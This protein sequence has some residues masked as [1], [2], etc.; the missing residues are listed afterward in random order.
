MKGHVY[1]SVF[2]SW[3]SPSQPV[4]A[5]P[6]YVPIFQNEKSSNLPQKLFWEPKSPLHIVWGGE[7]HEKVCQNC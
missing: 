5:G 3:F 4:L 2:Q 6:S 1:N 7:Q